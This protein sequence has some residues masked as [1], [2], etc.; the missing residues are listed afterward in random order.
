MNEAEACQQKDSGGIVSNGL[1]M[2]KDAIMLFI[3]ALEQGR[4]G[5]AEKCEQIC[6]ELLNFE[7]VDVRPCLAS[8]NQ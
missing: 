5:D 8:L 6:A 7:G 3:Q 2:K 1:Q 4:A